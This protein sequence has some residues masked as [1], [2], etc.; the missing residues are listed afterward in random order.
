[1]A[2]VLLADGMMD[3]KAFPYVPRLHRPPPRS[4]P[5]SDFCASEDE[6]DEEKTKGGHTVTV[7]RSCRRTRFSHVPYPWLYVSST[8][9][10]A[11]SLPVPSPSS[12]R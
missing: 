10:I 4:T 7:C 12:I 6:E 3:I 1:M 5:G 9:L 2:N 11:L 8:C